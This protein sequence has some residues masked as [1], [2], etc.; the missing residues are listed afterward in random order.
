LTG[1]VILRLTSTVSGTFAGQLLTH[2]ASGEPFTTSSK[3]PLHVVATPRRITVAISANRGA[4]SIAATLTAPLGRLTSQRAGK[5]R[6]VIHAGSGRTITLRASTTT[7]R[8][9]GAP[10]RLTVG[11]SVITSTG[12]PACR[13]GIVGKLEILDFDAIRK[14]IRTADSVTVILPRECGGSSLYSDAAG[15]GRTVVKVGFH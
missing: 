9:Q 2:L 15:G 8:S 3:A 14:A 10:T 4:K 7:V 5:G 12:L 6:V 11:L 1:H 13:T